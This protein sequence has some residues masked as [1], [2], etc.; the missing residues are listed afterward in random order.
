MSAVVEYRAPNIGDRVNCW[1]VLGALLFDGRVPCACVCGTRRK[2][3]L[4][5]L[6][7]GPRSC[8]CQ[9][10]FFTPEWCVHRLL[11][12]GALHFEFGKTWL[13]PACGDGAIVRAVN[14]WVDAAA[15]VEPGAWRR[16]RWFLQDIRGEMVLEAGRSLL[17]AEVP[18]R[19]RA[20]DF[21]ADPLCEGVDVVIGNPPFS[22]ATEFVRRCLETCAGPVALLLQFGWLASQERAPLLQETPPDV[23][24]L[25]NRPS[26]TADGQTDSRDYF[27]ACWPPADERHRRE[28]S[29]RVLATTPRALRAPKET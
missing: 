28:G 18:V 3:D 16:P 1:T 8:G 25:P 2:V 10:D 13:E 15:V 26:F 14:A 20:G 19:G 21:L 7:A 24:V 17:D 9:E 12:T 6:V 11:D 23:Y 5:E 22:L 29:F 27:W 4:R